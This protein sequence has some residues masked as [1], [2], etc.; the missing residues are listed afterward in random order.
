MATYLPQI[1]ATVCINGTHAIHGYPLYYRDLCIQPIPYKMECVRITEQ[2][3]ADFSNMFE[4]PQAK[5]HPGSVLPVEKA[6]GNILFIV[7]EGDRN[8]NSKAFATDI[9]ERMKKLGKTHCALLSYPNAGH[10]I[11][12]PSSPF[13]YQSWLPILARPLLWGGEAQAHAAAQVHSWSE[14]QTFLHLHLGPTQSSSL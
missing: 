5:L 8:Y 3:T 4:D 1:G 6:Q 7:G 2:G 12:P 10:L 14:I 9:M 11:E 13:C